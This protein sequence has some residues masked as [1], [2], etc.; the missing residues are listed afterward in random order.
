M[1]LLDTGADISVI[2]ASQWDPSWAVND[3]A[4]Q[5]AGVGGASLALRAAKHLNWTFENHQGY[6]RPLKL[7]GLAY[8]L[9]GRD[10]LQ[11]LGLHLTT[12]EHLQ[13]N[14]LGPL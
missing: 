3:G 6:F 2:N 9:W 12:P 10:L 5:V 14:M 8:A 7:T 4:A 11:Q 13:L 1:G